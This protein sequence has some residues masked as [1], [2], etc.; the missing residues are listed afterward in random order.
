MPGALSLAASV[1]AVVDVTAKVAGASIKLINL[2]KEIPN[3]SDALLKEDESPQDFEDF[4]LDTES[5]AAKIPLPQ[6]V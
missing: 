5:E 4:L 2:W 3:I 6:Q 1:I